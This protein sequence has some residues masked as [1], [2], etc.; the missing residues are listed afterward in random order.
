MVL[1]SGGVSLA[2]AAPNIVLR[3]A[4]TA[5]AAGAHLAPGAFACEVT[6]GGDALG[7]HLLPVALQFLGNELGKA[8]ERAL[9]HLRARDADHAGVVGLDHD[10]DVDFGGGALSLRRADAERH[11]QSER[12]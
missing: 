2:A 8:R 9:P 3:S 7:R 5:A 12:Q 1:G 10:P 6:A 4:D 11:L